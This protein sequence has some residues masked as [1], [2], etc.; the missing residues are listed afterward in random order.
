[1]KEQ[2]VTVTTGSIVLSVAWAIIDKMEK[3]AMESGRDPSFY[4]FYSPELYNFLEGFG[5]LPPDN[6]IVYIS[7]FPGRGGEEK[8]EINEKTSI[9]FRRLEGDGRSYRELM[10]AVYKIPFLYDS[11]LLRKYS[12]NTNQT[13]VEYVLLYL[14]DSRLVYL[15]GERFHVSIPSIQS[16]ITS[17]HTH[18]EHSCMLSHADVESALDSL[19]NGAVMAGAVTSKCAVV[20]RRKN[21]VT[22]EDFIELK[23]LASFLR[24]KKLDYR[25]VQTRVYELNRKLE[26]VILDFLYY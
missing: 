3:D 21:L 18:P 24:R 10:E 8:V 9:I 22:E 14:S 17:L 12:L 20:L 15:E 23:K 4:I 26:S 2:G 5:R 1:M 7:P 11:S 19:V 16:S 6:F 25:L 13:G